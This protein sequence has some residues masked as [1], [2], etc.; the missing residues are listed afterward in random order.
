MGVQGESPTTS[1]GVQPPPNLGLVDGLV[2]LSA[3]VQAVVARVAAGAD[4]SMAQARLLGVLRDRQPS[5]AQLAG[6]LELD[7]SSATGLIDRAERRG[8]V[9]RVDV[10][11]DGR[12]FRVLLTAKGRR[13]T[14]ELAD[15]VA[16]GV[17]ALTDGL[18]EA[19]RRKLAHLAGR[20]VVHDATARGIDL[21]TSTN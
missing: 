9:R 6:L 4:L 15:E 16:R 10:P 11:E 5:M 14:E 13:L 2:Q 12:S 20:V 17:A 3:A 8:L 21:S 19:D 18:S 7:K 1:R